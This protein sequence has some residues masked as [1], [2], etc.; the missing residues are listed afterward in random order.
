MSYSTDP[1]TGLGLRTPEET[2]SSEYGCEPFGLGSN[3]FET[4]IAP[5]PLVGLSN[6][7]FEVGHSHTFGPELRLSPI[8]DTDVRKLKVRR[9][10]TLLLRN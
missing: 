8:F 7:Q 4:Q 10:S 3:Y 2:Q 6:P 9:R 1:Y 5:H